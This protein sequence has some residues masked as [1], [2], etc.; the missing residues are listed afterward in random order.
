MIW[1]DALQAVIMLVGLLVVC[2]LGTE[3]A[4]GASTVYNTA[5][6]IGRINLNKYVFTFVSL[7]TFVLICCRSGVTT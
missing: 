3:Q 2:I 1:T 7:L 6:Q 5:K 4:G